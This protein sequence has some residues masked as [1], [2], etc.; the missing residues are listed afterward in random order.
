[1]LLSAINRIVEL[2]TQSQLV[3]VSGKAFSTGKLNEL[4]SPEAEA[5]V[6]DIT[7]LAGMCEYIKSHFDPTEYSGSHLGI[8]VTGPSRVSLISSLFGTF[9]QREYLMVATPYV[10]DGF[11]FGEYLEFDKFITDLQ[12]HFVQDEATAAVLRVV[13]NISAE[14]VQTSVDDGVSQMVAARS[15]VTRVSQV[16]V[17]NPVELRPFR[18][19]QE[20]EQPA[21]KFVLRLQRREENLPKAALFEVTD[22]Q[23]KVVAIKSIGTYLREQDLGVPIFA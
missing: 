1:M 9:R 22:N 20:I 13:G 5:A 14:Q 3:K 11:R 8:I 12:A 23:W 19:F 18:T 16:P 10:S 7:T 2:A 21:S 15:G 17:P 6:L 4:P